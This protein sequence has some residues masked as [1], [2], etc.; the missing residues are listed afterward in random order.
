MGFALTF[1]GIAAAMVA[2][3]RVRLL[4]PGF[5]IHVAGTTLL[6][7]LLLAGVGMAWKAVASATKD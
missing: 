4:V 3:S 5:Q 1:V 7:S 2:I 6:A